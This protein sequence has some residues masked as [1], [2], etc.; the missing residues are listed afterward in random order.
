MC[1]PW[2]WRSAAVWPEPFHEEIGG[3]YV[4]ELLGSKKK[5]NYAFFCF[6]NY[7]V[8]CICGLAPSPP[9]SRAAR[10]H[11][12]MRKKKRTWGCSSNRPVAAAALA[13]VSTL[14]QFQNP[15]ADDPHGA[16][17]ESSRGSVRGWGRKFSKG[18]CPTGKWCA[19][20]ASKMPCCGRSFRRNGPSCLEINQPFVDPTA[21]RNMV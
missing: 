18:A 11:A 16:L 7:V 2:Y 4:K 1:P 14:K 20:S 15:R 5:L 10:R 17:K 13:G 9:Q 8:G 3:D 19:A 12:R 21:V 6:P